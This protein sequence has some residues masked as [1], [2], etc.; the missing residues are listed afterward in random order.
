[1]FIRPALW[2][3][4]RFGDFQSLKPNP[5][6]HRIQPIEASHLDWEQVPDHSKL[7]EF[8][9]LLKLHELGEAVCAEIGRLDQEQGI[10]ADAEA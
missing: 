1:M 10:K 4:L 7:C 9:I 2:V 5:D 3:V 6:E 8:R